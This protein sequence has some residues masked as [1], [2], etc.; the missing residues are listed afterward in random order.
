MAMSLLDVAPLVARVSSQTPARIWV[1]QT[2]PPS[3]SFDQNSADSKP[4]KQTDTFKHHVALKNFMNEEKKDEI[5]TY[6]L[7]SRRN[8]FLQNTVRVRSL[9]AL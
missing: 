7:L 4:Q 3:R 6:K 9:F 5:T 1:A 8:P 2:S